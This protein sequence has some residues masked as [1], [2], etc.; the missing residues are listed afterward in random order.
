MPL[1]A[2]GVIVPGIFPES[3]RKD[4]E[5]GLYFEAAGVILNALR[6]R[7]VSLGR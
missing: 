3:F 5:V 7:K 2:V 1:G 4:G 6:L